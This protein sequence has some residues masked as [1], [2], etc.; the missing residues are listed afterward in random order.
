MS[1]FLCYSFGSSKSLLGWSGTEDR[2]DTSS[3]LEVFLDFIVKYIIAEKLLL[4]RIFPDDSSQYA[5]EPIL[6][7][8]TENLQQTVQSLVQN[9]I[10]VGETTWERCVFSQSSALL[11]CF[12]LI[13][14]VC[15]RLDLW[16]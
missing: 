6:R 13:T 5:I 1:L 3:P 9:I 16:L 8:V 14:F 15:K 4:D 11:L 2:G 7:P 10:K 12:G